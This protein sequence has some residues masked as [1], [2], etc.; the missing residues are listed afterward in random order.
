MK[1][2]RTLSSGIQHRL[3]AAGLLAM[4]AALPAIAN[5]AANDTYTW[6]AELVDLD[7]S[8][9]TVTVQSRLVSNAEVDFESLDNGD[10]VTLTWSGIDT[11][12]GVRRIVDGQAPADDR[13]TLPIEFV[14]AEHD[15]RYVRFKVAVPSDDVAK[16]AA[17]EAGEW[18]T[19]TSPR[20]SARFE[21]AVAD[22]R[23]YTDVAG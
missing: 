23:P 19:A 20:R 13:L 7:E 14:S 10:R 15:N 4:A 18:I 6:S 21:E 5:D 9:R 11:A 22:V 17:L 16:L 12:A 1:S 8:A 3:V 2:E